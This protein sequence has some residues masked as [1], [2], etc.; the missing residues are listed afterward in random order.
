M[1]ETQ[2]FSRGGRPES[3]SR[4]TGHALL[5]HLVYPPRDGTKQSSEMVANNYCSLPSIA[6][7]I[8][9]RQRRRRE[10]YVASSKQFTQEIYWKEPHVINYLDN[11][12]FKYER[13]AAIQKRRSPRVG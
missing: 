13:N 12:G 2:Q 9:L 6:H 11:N 4:I 7:S 1:K 8:S 5:R 3:A 10:V